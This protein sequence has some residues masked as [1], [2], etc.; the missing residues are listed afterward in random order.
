MENPVSS[1]ETE[2]LGR[3]QRGRRRA[4]ALALGDERGRSAIARSQSQ[5]DWVIGRHGGKARPEDRVWPGREHLERTEIGD[6]PVELETKPQPLALADP[7]FLHQPDFFGQLFERTKA[8]EQFLGEIG[9]LQEPLV[10]LAPFDQR[11][12]APAAAVDH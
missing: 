6:R 3:L 11:P 4:T 9:Y 12:G 5:S 1:V 7:I 10:E 2:L 8:V